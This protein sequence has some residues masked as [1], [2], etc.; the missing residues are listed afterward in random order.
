M[1]M[2]FEQIDNKVVPSGAP[3]GTLSVPSVPAGVP[4]GRMFLWYNNDIITNIAS[5]TWKF[6]DETKLHHRGWNTND[7]TEL[8]KD[9]QVADE[10]QCQ[11]MLS[12]VYFPQQHTWQLLYPQWP[13]RL[14]GPSH[15]EGC[16]DDSWRRLHWFL[17]WT[18][19]SGGTANEGGGA[20]NQLDQQSLTA[21][22]VAVCGRLQL[23]VSH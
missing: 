16:W 18:R 3:S 22:S 7:I 9:I 6:V 12:N 15:A 5:K 14:G 8:Q 19:R 2:I 21:L 23:W 10:L 11:K 13:R 20:T 1:L 17:L 4:Q